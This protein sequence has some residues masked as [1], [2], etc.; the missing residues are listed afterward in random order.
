MCCHNPFVTDPAP[1]RNGLLCRSAPMVVWGPCPASTI[2][3]SGSSMVRRRDAAMAT[4]S[5]PGR[6]VRPIDPANNRSPEKRVPPGGRPPGDPV[7]FSGGS[8][9]PDPLAEEK[10][11]P[12]TPLAPL[13]ETPSP[14]APSGSIA[15]SSPLERV[16]S[17][18]N[19]Y[20]TEPRVCP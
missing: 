15:Q 17:P 8:H 16:N 9:P 7:F 10:P 12:Q 2:V 6:S 5:P 13:G 18:G 1:F 11:S 14:L 20:V 19:P 3:S 4:S